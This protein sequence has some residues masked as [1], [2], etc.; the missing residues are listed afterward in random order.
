MISANE[1][2]Y[3]S[4]DAAMMRDDQLTQGLLT[5]RMLAWCIDAVLISAIA[6]VIWVIMAAFTILT[7]GIGAPLFALLAIL[8]AFYGWLFLVSTM[9]ASPGQAAMGL[10]VVRDADFGPP[11]P[12]QALIYIVGYCITMALGVIWTAVAVVTRRHRTIHDMLAG[13]VVVRRRALS[14][15]LTPGVQGWNMGGPNNIGGGR[16][17]A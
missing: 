4:P 1:N 12:L 2:P 9:Q 8:P 5:R 13:L 14:N 16:P 17:Y 6:A 11:T 10:I 7:F 15:L 3:F